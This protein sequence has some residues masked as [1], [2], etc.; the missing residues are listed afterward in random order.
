MLFQDQLAT[1]RRWS[2]ESFE[3]VMMH[4]VMH[5][6]PGTKLF[7]YNYTERELS[8]I[9]EA[10]SYGDMDIIPDAFR[11]WGSFPAQVFSQPA[12]KPYLEF[13]HVFGVFDMVFW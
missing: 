1:W 13:W 6:H 5:V 11:H 8:G 12:L 9:F 3:F 2:N 10:T 7:L 4:Q